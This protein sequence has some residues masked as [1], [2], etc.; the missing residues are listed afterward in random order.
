MKLCQKL[1]YEKKKFQIVFLIET[2]NMSPFN[3]LEKLI[4]VEEN[5]KKKQ[6]IEIWHYLHLF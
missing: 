5:K 6:Q 3:L 4:N 1:M 2:I